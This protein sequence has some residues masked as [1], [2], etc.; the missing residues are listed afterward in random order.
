[1]NTEMVFSFTILFG[2][3]I[4]LLCSLVILSKSRKIR[5]DVRNKIVEEQTK[6]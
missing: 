2:A 4:A 6:Q 3:T 1:M 5:D